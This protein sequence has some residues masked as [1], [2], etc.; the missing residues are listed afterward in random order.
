MRPEPP[1]A[2]I[3]LVQFNARE[4]VRVA[5]AAAAGGQSVANFVRRAALE[6]SKK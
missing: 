2:S 6:A 3:V 4:Y 1:A 5:T